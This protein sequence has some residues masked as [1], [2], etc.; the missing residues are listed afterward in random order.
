MTSLIG[1]VR[2]FTGETYDTA[3]TATETLRQVNTIN[4]GLTTHLDA[5]E[6]GLMP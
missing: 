5:S 1:L 2:P 3:E 6:I 4:S